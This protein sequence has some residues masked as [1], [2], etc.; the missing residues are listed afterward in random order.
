MNGATTS[1]SGTPTITFCYYQNFSRA[2]P[3]QITPHSTGS[4]LPWASFHFVTCLQY[5]ATNSPT[6]FHLSI[7]W[8]KICILFDLLFSSLSNNKAI[9]A[10]SLNESCVNVSNQTGPSK[11]ISTQ[12][13]VV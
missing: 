1:F 4:E 13:R 3:P 9:Q 5:K 10:K 11:T 6:I 2:H 8:T 12:K 7:S